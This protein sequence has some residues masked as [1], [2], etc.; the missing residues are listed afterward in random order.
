MTPETHLLPDDHTIG[1]AGYAPSAT[2]E[3]PRRVLNI[4][5]AV[6]ALVLAL[7][8]FVLIAIAIKLTSRGSVFYT[9]ERVGLDTRSTSPLA[10]DPR[11]KRDVGGRPFMMYKFRTMRVDA[12]RTTGAV[13]AKQ[14]DPRVTPVGRVLRH[15]R[16]DELPQLMNVLKGDMNVV[17]PRPER[18]TIFAELRMKIPNY[19][20][21]QRVRPGITGHAQVNLEYDTD[22]ESVAEKVRYD[23]EYLSQQSIAA[24]LYIMAKTVPVMLFRDKVLRRVD[25]AR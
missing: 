14:R 6:V 21:R 25:E 11:R 24:D 23:L 9:Q 5:V 8:L 20:V 10:R 2:D 1:F 15:C 12:E 17:G 18:P 3:G 19:Q 22:V 4:L 7:P 13:W 16:L